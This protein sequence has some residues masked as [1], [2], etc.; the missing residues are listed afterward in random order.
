MLT[1]FGGHDVLFVMAVEAEYGPHLRRRF[2]PLLTGVGP[3]EAALGLSESLTR[4]SLAGTPP[5]LVVSLGSAGSARLQHG[6]VYQA[7]SVSW[8]DI[9]ASPLGIPRGITP[10]SGLPATLP[11]GPAI[12]GLAQASLSTGA[13]IV[14]GAAYAAIP[15]DMVDMETWSAARACMRAGLPMIALRGISDGQSELAGLN[16]WASYLPLVD[17]ALAAALD[18]LESALQGGLLG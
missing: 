6:A 7:R 16:D 4:L 5:D 18:R 3:V 13:N 9:D 11:L 14:S 2:T 8:R 10:F 15:E 12:P 1:R 17:K